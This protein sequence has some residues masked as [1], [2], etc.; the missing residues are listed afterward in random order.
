M[1]PAINSITNKSYDLSTWEGVMACVKEEKEWYQLQAVLEAK[2]K[3]ENKITF[4]KLWKK[5]LCILEELRDLKHS[6]GRLLNNY[7]IG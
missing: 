7:R 3:E 5:T 1:K 4:T 2:R 6:C